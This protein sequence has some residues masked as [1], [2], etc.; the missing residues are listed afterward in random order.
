M[1]TAPLP[2]RESNTRS[3]L[4]AV[5]WRIIATV[6]TISIA[7]LVL[8]DVSLALKVGGIEFVTKFAVYYFHER[9]WQAI[10]HGSFP[11]VKGH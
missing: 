7:W 5:S 10:P 3:L 9:L 4:K 8:G 6:T 2:L 11:R 1:K